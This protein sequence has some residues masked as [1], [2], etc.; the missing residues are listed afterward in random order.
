MGWVRGK[1]GGERFTVGASPRRSSSVG[2]G[3][4]GGVGAVEVVVGGLADEVDAESNDGDAQP[5]GGVPEL[6][7]QHRVL[8]PLVPPLEEL[9]RLPQR[10]RHAATTVEQS[11]PADAVRQRA[12]SKTRG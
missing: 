1:G 3:V 10:F 12:P 7:R 9:P 6:V 5:G 2:V 4:G 8:P 11:A